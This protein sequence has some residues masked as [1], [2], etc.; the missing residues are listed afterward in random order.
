[1]NRILYIDEKTFN[2]ILIYC[3]FYYKNVF[4]IL[5]YTGLRISEFCNLK[6]SDI[7]L[8][9]KIVFVN[10][11]NSKTKIHKRKVFLNKICF[12]AFNNI[13]ARKKIPSDSFL[14]YTPSSNTI[15]QYI[16]FINKKSN[17][18]FSAH[19]FRHS[20]ITNFY[21]KCKDLNL[22]KIAAGHK[23][24]NSTIIYMHYSEIDLRKYF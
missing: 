16:K 17:I 14:C 20:F 21:N 23:S 24:I 9:N 13:I 1:M 2:N 19:S 4:S 12:I 22:T 18:H 7:D 3:N 15:K 5:Y 11:E 8:E 6:I 10:D